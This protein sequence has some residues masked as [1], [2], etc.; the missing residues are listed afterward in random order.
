[1]N[2]QELPMSA[3]VTVV[4]SYAHSHYDSLVTVNGYFV[5]GAVAALQSLLTAS[6]NAAVTAG[7]GFQNMDVAGESGTVTP[8]VGGANGIF[9]LSNQTS[10]GGSTAGAANVSV[11][12]PSSYSTIIVQAPGT[13]TVN[14]G[15]VN[16]TL[17]IFDQNASV[18]YFTGGGSGTVVAGGGGDFVDATG[19]AWSIST[20]TIGN[21]TINSTS[22]N[23]IVYT[24]GSG[25]ATGNALDT[26]S[27]PSNVIGMAS[28]NETVMSGGSNDLIASYGGNDVVSVNNS[29]NVL[30][31]GG[32]DTVYAAAGSTA[33]K[34]FFSSAVAGG[35]IVFFN[36][37]G[38]AASVTG[39]SSSVAAAGSVTAFGG[40]GGGYYEGGDGGNNSL[41]G[42]TGNTTLI[43]AGVGNIIEA[44][45]GSNLLEA[46]AGG[47]STIVAGVG[48]SNNNFFGSGTTSINSAG[49]GV[50]AYFLGASGSETISGSDYASTNRYILLQDSTGS[51][52]DNI[53]GFRYGVDHIYI[54]PTGYGETTSGVSIVGF[55]AN[56]GA[57]GG[58][59]ITLSDN[60]KINLFGV[61]L[62][63]SQEAAAT[64]NGGTFV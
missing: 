60:T 33:V 11:N 49:S 23:T 24:Y 12:V 16:G 46:A 63:A 43:G 56:L 58:T 5:P 35:T 30:V 7:G 39:S 27:A 3:S 34:A 26:T 62:T 25:L 57:G 18:S 53:I 37:S 44:S 40:A 19:G 38:T 64:L 32:S 61:N 28:P 47:S 1:M 8:S 9:E 2:Y 36:E 21:D 31:A 29:A 17:A 22:S 6:S 42:G 54:N 45:S 48:T 51:G 15:G 59:T 4:G 10:T 13:E 55:S 14:G 52:T 20:A 41:I 50:E